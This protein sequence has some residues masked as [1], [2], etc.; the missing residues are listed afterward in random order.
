MKSKYTPGPWSVGKW[1]ERTAGW[2]IDAESVS[3]IA[4]ALYLGGTDP[5]K[6]NAHLIAAAPD[7]LAACEQAIY[8]LKGRE[9][10]GFLRAAIK[11]ARG[12]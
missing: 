4:S 6:A 1:D 10:D 3:H 5:A 7:L 2:H 9:H 8:A 12:E 11:K